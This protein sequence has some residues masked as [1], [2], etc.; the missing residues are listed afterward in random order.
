MGVEDNKFTIMVPHKASIQSEESG[1]FSNSVRAAFG[2]Y[3]TIAACVMPKPILC[4]PL[5]FL[6]ELWTFLR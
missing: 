3:R 1:C 5:E 4:I 2:A 6:A